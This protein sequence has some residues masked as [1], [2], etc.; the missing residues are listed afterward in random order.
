MERTIP[1]R[2]QDLTAS[3]ATLLVGI[4]FAVV[5]SIDMLTGPE[6]SVSLFYLLPVVLVSLRWGNP[7]GVVV[8]M[9]AAVAW[10]VVD[11]ASA[12][13]RSYVLIVVWNAVVRFG[14]FG[15][16]SRL[17]VDLHSAVERE[18]ALARTDP[19]TRLPN[20]RAFREIAQRE[21]ARAARLGSGL[22]LVVID[23]DDFKLVN[24]RRGHEGGDEV[25]CRFA[26]L[27]EQNLRSVDVTARTG[28]DEFAVLLPDVDPVAAITVLQR[29]RETLDSDEAGDIGCSMGV[30]CLAGGSL[31]DALR[32]ADEALYLAKAAGKG[33]IVVIDLASAPGHEPDPSTQPGPQSVT[34]VSEVPS[35]AS[36]PGTGVAGAVGVALANPAQAEPP[37]VVADRRGAQL[38]PLLLVAPNGDLTLYDF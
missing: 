13:G 34:R 9:G 3:V 27:A 7:P 18:A 14:F 26:R 37:T 4:L 8:A 2:V 31:S 16:V 17:L 20:R 30:A 19:L 6:L 21:L 12:D 33:S 32:S 36:R 22:A 25:L 29:F 15:L 10:F 5:I 1:Q 35:I 38:H 11:L 23:L 24:D 28:G